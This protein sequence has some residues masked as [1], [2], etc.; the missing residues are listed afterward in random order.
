MREFAHL[1]L[2]EASLLPSLDPGP[3]PD[4]SDRVLA[5]SVSGEVLTRLAGVF[6]RELDLEHAVD[7]EGFVAVAVDCICISRVGLE[8]GEGR[9]REKG[10]VGASKRKRNM[11]ENRNDQHA[12]SIFSGAAFIKWFTW[13]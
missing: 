3:S 2:G 12:H 1:L 5:L 11:K 8:E 7:A 4:I 6:A 13:P 10:W 9:D